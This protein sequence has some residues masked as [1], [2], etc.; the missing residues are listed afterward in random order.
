MGD[1]KCRG[2]R[3]FYDAQMGKK[4]SVTPDQ[5]FGFRLSTMEKFSGGNGAPER[6]EISSH[7]QR[8]VSS[9]QGSITGTDICAQL[10]HNMNNKT[11]SQKEVMLSFME[12]WHGELMMQ[13]NCATKEA[14]TF[15][16]QCVCAMLDHLT[17]PR[18]LVSHYQE[19]RTPENKAR[20]IWAMMQV[21][22]RM[23]EI[24]AARFK[25]HPTITT[26][27]SNFIMKTRVSETVVTDLSKKIKDAAN[28]SLKVAALEAE[29]KVLKASMKKK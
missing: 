13:C 7:V 29:F 10:V 3:Y 20:I 14:W 8:L 24:I 11:Q 4:G 2:I 28:V 17:P 27:M 5:G 19:W 15:I 9:I 26:V 25:S 22:I 12:Q 23:D 21:H 16:G 18:I 6:A 1:M